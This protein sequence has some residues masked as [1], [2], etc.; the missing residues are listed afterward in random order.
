MFCIAPKILAQ[1][2]TMA[3]GGNATGVGGTASFSVGQV[4]YRSQTGT[5]GT[6]TQGVQQPFEILTLSGAEFTD[7]VLEASIYP[8]PT[9]SL[10][11]LTIK[12]YA[13]ENLNYQLFDIQGK[14]IEEKKVTLESTII[15]LERFP[16]STYILKINSN[17]KEIKTFKIIKN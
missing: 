13:L 2:S 10:V 6:I 7:I 14:F 16:T 11:N 4:V 9:T 5:T 3:A 12:N 17:F 8:N 1:Q 15:N